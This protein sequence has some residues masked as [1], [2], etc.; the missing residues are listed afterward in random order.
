MSSWQ[1]EYKEKT[2]SDFGAA[3]GAAPAAAG[4][5]KK[6]EKK[7]DDKKKDEKAVCRPP[8]VPVLAP[9]YT[10]PAPPQPLRVSPLTPAHGQGQV[11]DA[12]AEVHALEGVLAVYSYAAGYAPSKEDVRLL[13]V[14]KSVD[15][16]QLPN[17]AR[18]AR[19]VASYTAEELQSWQ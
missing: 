6:D 7:K 19:H 1:V 12:E 17:V 14:A 15:L 13:Q 2:G 10:T 3:P 4:K 8:E 11:K 16:T 18:W 5:E 9:V